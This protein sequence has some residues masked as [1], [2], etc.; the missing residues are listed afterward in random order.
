AN[1]HPAVLEAA[2][3]GVGLVVVSADRPARLRGTG[4]NQ[5][6]DQ[7]GIFGPLVP[8]YDV[9]TVAELAAVPAPAD[10]VVHVNLQLDTPLVP[11]VSVA[12]TGFADIEPESR[13]IRSLRGNQ[14]S[15]PQGPRTVVVAGDDAGPPAR[16]LAEAAGWPLL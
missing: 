8:S 7:V 14:T 5:T 1:L 11:D 12:T 15:L 3:A 2:H 4:A 13:Q 9:A 16:Q 10:S 6:T